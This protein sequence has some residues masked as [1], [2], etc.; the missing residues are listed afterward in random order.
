[1]RCLLILVVICIVCKLTL[2]LHRVGDSVPMMKRIQYNDQRTQFSEVPYSDTPR[3]GLPKLIKIT[4]VQS[5]IEA[6]HS[7]NPSEE[8]QN[9][10]EYYEKLLEDSKGD[11]KISFAF[12][13]P[14]F[15]TPWI[16][17]FSKSNDKTAKFNFL[18]QIDFIFYYS[19]DTIRDIKHNLQY[20][21]QDD[22]VSQKAST[23]ASDIIVNYH[24]HEVVEKDTSLGLSVLY[25]VS[26]VS[27]AVVLLFTLLDI[28]AFK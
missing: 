17:I 23:I 13:H 15:V 22:P 27:G 19:G 2:G 12:H 26:F 24:W 8:Q 5:I 18:K 7:I 9:D 11:M 1:M 3:F 25:F 14:H 6:F 21:D 10:E 16:T 28:A 20:Y 4:G